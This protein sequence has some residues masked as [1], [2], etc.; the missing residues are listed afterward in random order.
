VVGERAIPEPVR[1]KAQALGAEGEQWLCELSAC[2]AALEREWRISVGDAIE[3][4]TGAYVANAETEDGIAAVVKLAMPDGLT[5]HA[6]FARELQTLRLADGRPHVRVLRADERRRVMLLERLGRPLV[7]L[8]LPVETQAEI[9][10]STLRQGWRP[11]L[12]APPLRTGAEQAEFLNAFVCATWERLERPCSSRV[13]ERAVQCAQSRRA[14]FDATRAVFIH[15]DAHPANVL[16]DPSAPNEFCL[17]DPD[18]ML[19][20][21]A[22]DVSIPLRDWTEE[23]LASDP[24]ERGLAWCAQLSECAVVDPRAVWEWAF[25]ERVSTGLFLLR[26]GDVHGANFLDIAEAWAAVRPPF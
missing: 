18:G 2:I 14:V 3:G 10:A 9:I 5:G 17:I 21:P 22:H 23:L 6:P 15:G 4:G 25:L 24:V 7:A 13:I 8:R 1:R 11:V 12:A 20:E 26:L 16:E 19:S